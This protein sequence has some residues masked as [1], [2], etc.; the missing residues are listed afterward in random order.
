MSDKQKNKPQ[1][2]KNPK[3][4]AGRGNKK[5]IMRPAIIKSVSLHALILI[6]LLVSFSFS[7]KPLVFAANTPAAQ[8]QGPDIVQATFVDSNVIQQQRREKAQ[9]EADAQR[10][11]QE[12]RRQEQLAKQKQENERKRREQVERKKRED[13]A[14][15]EQERVNA[16][17]RERQRQAE[18]QR[19]QKEK[20]EQQKRQRELDDALADQLKQEQ[21]AMA[22]AQ[23]QQVMTEVQ[24]YSSLINQTVSRS[25]NVDGFAKDASCNLIV[26][27]AP[28]G[29]VLE[30]TI[31]EG[32]QALCRE[33]ESAILRLSSLPMSPDPAVHRQM[34]PL[35]FI[36]RPN[37]Q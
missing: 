18:I 9:A 23:Q 11:A 25:I 10:R 20:E 32:N 29:L 33:T 7:D 15:A 12:K 35:N 6:S 34:N 1:A 37:S 26:R 13:A 5:S 16:L 31:V 8:A 22:S 2:S 36:M 4:A 30:V 3:K 27:L 14:K 28:D 17:E 19:Q 21:A 24:K